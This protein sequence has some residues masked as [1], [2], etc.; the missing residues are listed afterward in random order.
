MMKFL[1]IA[2]LLLLSSM[3][4]K[5][6]DADLLIRVDD[7]GM[8]HAVNLATQ[9]IINT[10]IAFSASLMVAAPWF[11]EAVNIVANQSHVS[12]GLHLTLTSEF[13]Q[14]KWG[15]VASKDSV[16]SLVTDQGYFY[17]SV[18][19]FLLSDYRL[20][21]IE[22]EVRAQID[23]ALSAGLKVSYL[24]HH[25]GIARATPEIAA[26]IEKVANEYGLAI[27]RYYN[28]VPYNLF[29]YPAE[30]KKQ[31]FLD[32][33]KSMDVEQLNLFV[34]HPGKDNPELAVLFDLNSSVMTDKT[35]GLSNMSLHRKAELEALTDTDYISIIKKQ[36]VVNY[37]DVIKKYGLQGQRRDGIL[38]QS[39]TDSIIKARQF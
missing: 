27:S 6:V 11:N 28:E 15:P 25:M 2:L 20:I 1:R 31:A 26:V 5:N 32:K 36:R 21:D 37:N 16:S 9:E 18:A 33:L 19:D 35:T 3:I 13:K 29:H 24:D 34:M 17:S 38:Y 8:S 30:D 12:I 23:K 10:G 4:S 14:Y 22:T 7:V 39:K